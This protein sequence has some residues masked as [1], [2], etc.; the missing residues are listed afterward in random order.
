MRRISHNRS[1]KADA[2]TPITRSGLAFRGRTECQDETMDSLRV[3][4]PFDLQNEERILEE[5]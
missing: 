4:W 1:R 2:M 3:S 5:R